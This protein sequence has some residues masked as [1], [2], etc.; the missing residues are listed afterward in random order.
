MA[1]EC[2][3]DTVD[4]L[5]DF[6]HYAAELRHIDPVLWDAKGIVFLP[7]MWERTSAY[8][9]SKARKV[10][11]DSAQQVVDSVMAGGNAARAGS[12]R[13]RTGATRQTEPHLTGPGKEHGGLPFNDEDQ[14]A[15]L[16][17]LWNTE[18]KPGPAVRG[19]PAGRRQKALNALRLHPNLDDWRKVIRWVNGQKWCNAMGS[20]DHPNWRLDFDFVIRPGKVQNLLER[21]ASDSQQPPGTMGKDASRGRTGVQPGKF[22]EG[23][24]DRDEKAGRHHGSDT[25]A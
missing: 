24:R 10:Q 6:L 9:R 22:A 13:P 1:G 11:F 18:R 3:F 17:K 16:V 20:G 5:M 2:L 21:L 8:W 15:G 4:Q 25:E 14:V 7:A 23:L 12:I 19:L